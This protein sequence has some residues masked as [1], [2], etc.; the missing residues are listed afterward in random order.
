M[1]SQMVECPECGEWFFPSLQPSTEEQARI[2][3]AHEE[4]ERLHREGADRFGMIWLQANQIVVAATSKTDVALRDDY[5]NLDIRVK[6]LMS[7]AAWQ[8]AEYIC[9]QENLRK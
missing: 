2:N 5:G 1:K 3:H 8:V 4:F 9:E 7:A 6:A